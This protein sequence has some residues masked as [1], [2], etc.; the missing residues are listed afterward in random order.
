MPWKI[1]KH[2]NEDVFDVGADGNPIWV[3]DAGKELAVNGGRIPELMSEAA[4]NRKAKE[5]AE[6]KLAAFGDLDPVKA[7]EAI[8]KLSQVDQ[9]QLVAAGKVDEVRNALRTEFQ[10]KL[11][12]KDA[13]LNTI[14]TEAK[15]DKLAAAFAGSEFIK[16]KM[17]FGA[18]LA[19]EML[20]KHFDVRDG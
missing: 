12:A 20:G 16:T 1:K 9:G 7:R 13:E 15:R 19:K 5:A 2:N 18:D 11:D 3:D 8:D 14:K 4:K 17:G 6:Q 10:G